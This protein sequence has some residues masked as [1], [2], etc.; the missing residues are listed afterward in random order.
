MPPVGRI[1]EILPA[2]GIARGDAR[3]ACDGAGCGR[4][5]RWR[6]WAGW[7]GVCVRDGASRLGAWWYGTCLEDPD[8]REYGCVDDAFWA[9]VL[10]ALV[11]SHSWNGAGRG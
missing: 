4:G 9:Y 10:A 2:E 7:R 1:V 5:C 11:P 3:L 6:C 8:N